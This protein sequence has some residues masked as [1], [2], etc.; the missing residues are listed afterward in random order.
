MIEI[1]NNRLIPA[2]VANWGEIEGSISKQSDLMSILSSYATQ[3]WVSS[4]EFA[5]ETWVEN[6]SYITSSALEGYATESWVVSQSYIT[7]EALRGYATES[8]VVSQSYITS[9]ALSGYA[10]ESWVENKSY[11]TSSALEGYATESWVSNQGYLTS[12]PDTFATKEWVSDQGYL[13]SETLPSDIATQS[14]VESQGYLT[15]ETLPSDIAT[16][17]WVES[18]SYITS[19][20]LSGYATESWVT[21][22]NYMTPATD[23]LLQYDTD[24]LVP[25]NSN[26]LVDVLTSTEKNSVGIYGNRYMF[27]IPG[28]GVLSGLYLYKAKGSDYNVYKFNPNTFKFE[29]FVTPNIKADI[30]GRVWTDVYNHYFLGCSYEINFTKKGTGYIFE[31]TEHDLGSSHYLSYN[32]T[33][34]NIIDIGE[35]TFMVCPNE[36]YAYSFNTSTKE[37]NSIGWVT[38]C[39]YNNWYRYKTKIEGDWYYTQNG[40]MYKFVFDKNAEVPMSVVEMTTPPVPLINNAVPECTRIHQVDN[41]YIY[42]YKPYTYKWT[43]GTDEWILLDY[44]VDDYTF[45]TVGVVWNGNSYGYGYKTGQQKILVWNHGNTPLGQ[46][47]TWE[48]DICDGVDEQ[49]VR[50]AAQIVAVNESIAEINTEIGDAITITQNILS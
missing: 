50:L 42:Y 7:S 22:Q 33:L 29:Y 21:S 13:T 19:D 8:W 16:Q 48:A 49:A 26:K 43:P 23:P 37:F 18:Q 20:A 11:I 1:N 28:D 44:T 4:K 3:S 36:G 39:T 32:D 14:W 38:N 41:Y 47:Y 6:K 45:N 46:V 5:T 10:T 35:Q 40:V 24:R 9:E 25:V 31:L 34:D 17:S 12:V 27:V 30:N 15:S 2:I